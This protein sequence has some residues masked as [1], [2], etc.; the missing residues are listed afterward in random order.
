MGT[1]GP[2]KVIDSILGESFLAIRLAL[3]VVERRGL[4][5]PA[6]NLTAV[7][8]GAVTTVL[9][10]GPDPVT[11]APTVIGIRSGDATELTPADLAALDAA[12]AD[13]KQTDGMK[14]SSW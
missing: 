11:K 10:N 13:A 7:R 6:F 14:G 2:I 12:P 4:N 1:M 9:L 8:T 3:S 5:I